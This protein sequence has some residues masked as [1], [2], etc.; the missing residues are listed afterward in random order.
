MRTKSLKSR[1]RCGITL[2]V[3]ETSSVHMVTQGLSR[4]NALVT[5]EAKILG[6]LKKVGKKTE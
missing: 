1:L 5:K 2:P 6:L 3:C 4:R